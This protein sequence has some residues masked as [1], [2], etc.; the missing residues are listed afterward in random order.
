MALVRLGN[1]FDKAT[2]H[3]DPIIAAAAGEAYLA[4]L[5]LPL[6][7]PYLFRPE[8]SI[9]ETKRINRLTLELSLGTVADFL[10]TPA[11]G[12]VAVTM[13]IELIGTRASVGVNKDGI[14]DP[15][16]AKSYFHSFMRTYPTRHA[17][18]L[19]EW[20]LGSASDEAILGWLMYNHGA[21]GLPFIGSVAA[22]GND[23]I[24]GVSFHD[25][26][27]RYLNNV[28]TNSFQQQRQI[29]ADYNRH[30]ADLVSPVTRLGEYW[31]S[32]VKDGSINEGYQAK[33][34]AT[35][36]WTDATATDETDLLVW[37]VRSRREA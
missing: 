10:V 31:H 35:L 7:Y 19:R 4:V 5:D 9:L 32:F 17:D 22:P 1:Y 8:D 23:N 3:Y 2:P 13:A 18:V 24:T 14:K 26:G 34:P 20:V 28:Q 36:E 21:S 12:T 33:F 27:H 16:S 6:V 30:A 37:G 29:E 25:I 11:A 15:E